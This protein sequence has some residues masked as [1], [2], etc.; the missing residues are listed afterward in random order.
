MSVFKKVVVTTLIIAS[1]SIGIGAYIIYERGYGTENFT[2]DLSQLIE[3]ED[4]DIEFGDLEP[5]NF[6][7]NYPLG[8]KKKITVITK[9]GEVNI[10]PYDGDEIRLYIEGEVSDKF[11][12][13]YLKVRDTEDEIRFELFDRARNRFFLTREADGV[14]ISLEIP[15]GF[16]QNL[17]VENISDDIDVRNLNLLTI[18]IETV[19]GDIEIENGKINEIN[20]STVSGDVDMDSQVEFANVESVSGDILLEQTKGFDVET[21]SG[22]AI[23]YL[24]NDFTKSQ[25]ESVSG[26][27]TLNMIGRSEISY[28][29]ESVSGNITINL[30]DNEIN[31]GN[32]AKN[33][34]LNDKIVKIN[35]I[36]GNITLKN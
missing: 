6:A 17:R 26:D 35:T 20:F 5:L 9:L 32:K 33:K 16:D 25:G 1:V 18:D 28:D 23:I 4:L 3:G 36:S 29:F 12:E 15:R 22:D 2:R 13:D 10:S 30:D 24:N 7:K 21:V 14:E 8:N 27:I 19:S 11:L 31:L 34:G